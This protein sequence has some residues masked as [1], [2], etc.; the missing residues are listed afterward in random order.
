MEEGVDAGVVCVNK[1]MANINDYKIVGQK[2][3]SYY[4]LLIKEFPLKDKDAKT[5][6]EQERLGF[7]LFI[8]EHLTDKKDISD[9]VDLITDTDFNKNV[10]NANDD[11]LGIDAV[12]FNED[13]KTIQLFNF[14]YRDSFKSA[15]QSI[16]ETL[17]STK[18]L[19]SLS[20]ESAKN[21]K[22][23]IKT[24]ISEINTKLASNEIWKLKLYVVSNEN[25]KINKSKDLSNLEKQYGLEVVE[26]GLDQ[27]VEFIGLR[28]EPVDAQLI[29]E[30]DALMTFS[31][32][33][34]TTSKSYI[35]R[36]PLT[37]VIRITCNDLSLR[38]DHDIKDIKV[39]NKV[40][41]D[42]AVLFDNVRGLVRKSKYNENIIKSLDKTPHRFFIYNNGIT[43]TVKDLDVTEVNGGK[44]INF[45]L[46]ALQ[47]LNGGQTLRTIHNFNELNR[48]NIEKGLSD[49]QIIVR[50][51]KVSSDE[52]LNN[53]IA[54][55]TNSQ[56]AISNID[57][58]SLR[59]EQLQLEQYL[60][61]HSI[62]YARK[63][64][65]TGIDKNIDYLHRISMEKFG[66]ILFSLNGN[67]DRATNQKKTIFD[68]NYNSVFSGNT[69][70]I[71]DSPKHVKNYFNIKKEYEKKVKNVSDQKVF[72]ILYICKNVKKITTDDA[73]SKF[74]KEIKLYEGNGKT[75][76]SRK[77]IQKKFKEHIDKRF[78]IKNN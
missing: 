67:P 72:Y 61:D 32:N 45:S 11:D 48:K 77:L 29:L 20:K 27:I 14:K 69:F 12:N 8:L 25:F 36:L 7:Y 15:Q 44:K 33:S 54:E 59:P 30:K 51:F 28:P 49:A 74:E 24:K 76:D 41:L 31:E 63:S 34:L 68:K 38:G 6:K 47:I 64:G 70:S 78:R 2:C 43:M 3:I 62:V 40:K 23:R 52:E 17:V 16:N 21:L 9:L 18:F 57:L 35:V 50:I 75:S 39:L 58:K 4:S 13:E 56:N 46:K 66:Q 71:E 19:N 55:F 73:I 37:E 53:S 60:S 22:G 26:F 10:F 1:N 5:L 65:D 42:Y